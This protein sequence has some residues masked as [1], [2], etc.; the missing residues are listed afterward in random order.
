MKKQ[1][2]KLMSI[3]VVIVSMTACDKYLDLEP[4]QSISENIALDTDRNVK[5][6][7]NGAYNVFR[8]AALYNGNLLRNAE[9][10]GG[11]GEILWTGTFGGPRQ[12]AQKTMFAENEDVRLQWMDSYAGI[13]GVNNVLSALD[14]VNAADRDRVEGEALFLRALFHFDLVRF[15]GLQYEPGTTNSQLGVP[16]IATPT[17]GI[18]ESSFV[19]R[20]TVEEVYNQVIADLTR[21]SDLLPTSNGVF[22]TKGAADALLARVYLQ[23]GDYQNARDRANTVISSGLY[24]LRPNYA[25]VFNNDNASSEDIFVT[26]ITTQDPASSMTIFFSTPP[27]GGRDGDIDILEGHLNLY[28]PN[29]QRLALFYLGSGEMRSGKWN[30]QFG[31]VN[32]FRLAE[33]HLIRAET[34][35]RL[36]TSVGASPTEDVNV[37]RTR[38]GLDPKDNVT[39]DDILL[40]RRLELAHEGFKIHD[41]R[42]LKL[43]VG[44]RPYNSPELVFPIPAREII[45]NPNLDQNP[46]Y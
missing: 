30:N 29:D 44:S 25:A 5:N 14:V 6:V 43:N 1:Y 41:M 2:I 42:R 38:S 31:V 37:L 21:A 4:A 39:L 22:A 36:S 24:L 18:N 28:E 32:L 33:M 10:L 3:L 19:S 15:Y 26:Q 11:D 13:N 27:F 9:L 12:I 17:R 35:A 34:N 7:L 40:E 16:I 8:R 23:K 20:N 46:G 45:A